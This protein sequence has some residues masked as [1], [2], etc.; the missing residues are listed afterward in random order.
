MVAIT[1]ATGNTGRVIAE[2]LLARGEKVRVIGR[3][4]DRLKRFV[5]KG[6]EACVA[7]V[8]DVEALAKA[9]DGAQAV[10]AMIPPNLASTDPRGY[11]EKVSDALVRA[12]G[13]AR[14]THVVLLSS[15][16]AD[17]R[18]K[19]GPILGL[20][21]LEEKLNALPGLNAV[22][23]RAGYFMENLLPQVDVIR[24]FGIVGGPLRADL[25]VP[26]IAT[27]DIGAAAARLLGKRDFTGKQAREL[28]GQR[29]VTYKEVASVIGKAIGKP[30]L[31]YMQLSPQQL[32]PAL[33]QMGMSAGVADLLLEMAAALNSGHVAPLERRSAEN[34]TPTS[35]E[36]FVT[37]EFV[38]QFQTKA[39]KA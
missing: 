30:G 17:K 5:E 23:L 34:T 4:A 24:N 11:Q 13:A 3:N 22:Y 31:K 27:R 19:T 35:I 10:Y 7:D 16:G 18:E 6:A 9:F 36:T 14:V 33:T 12:L 29:D 21:N 38:P 1:G 28:L 26:M 15:Y 39:A 2:E 32:K 25:A 8:T 37:E 20:H